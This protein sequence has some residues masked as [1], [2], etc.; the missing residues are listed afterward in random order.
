MNYKPILA[1]FLILSMVLVPIVAAV[2]YTPVN[3]VSDYAEIIDENYE[4]QINALAGDI[5]HNTTIE[6]AVLTVPSL[7]GGDI[8]LFAVETFHDWKVGKKDVNNGLLIVVAVEDH[9][10]RIEVG[11]GLEPI[12]TDAMA[13]RIGRANFVDNFRVGEYGTGIYGAVTDI[14]KIIENDPDAIS[15]YSDSGAEINEFK[16]IGIMVLPLLLFVT[17]TCIYVAFC[18]RIYSKYNKESSI[19]STTKKPRLGSPKTILLKLAM[20]IVFS[21]AVW[22]FSN[23]ILG[24]NFIITNLILTLTGKPIKGGNLGGGGGFMGGSGGFSG[25][26]GFGGGRSGGGGASGGW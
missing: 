6:I 13:G 11:Y 21:V 8:D 3:Y 19:L 18:G 22:Y 5:E 23:W 14:Q 12:I 17:L 1:L 26:G 7:D 24:V 2:S 25:F 16:E 15:A 9:Q 10:W 4:A 20:L